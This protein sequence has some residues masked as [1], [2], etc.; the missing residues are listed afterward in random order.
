[1]Y[2][3]SKL[4]G[5][6]LAL[7]LG[8]LGAHLFYYKKYI[9]GLLYLIFCWTYIPVFLGWVDMIFIK[10]W[11]NQLN[12]INNGESTKNTPSPIKVLLD[13]YPNDIPITK[14]QSNIFGK[15]F[16]NEEEI[17]I[18]KY[19]RLKTPPSI[20]QSVEEVINPKK[21]NRNT[22]GIRVEF[23]YSRSHSDF[24]KKSANYKNRTQGKTREIP[25]QAYWTTFDHMNEQQLKWYFHWREETLKGNYLEVDLSYIFVFVYELLNYSFNTNAAFNVSM[26]VRLY[27]NYKEMHPKLSN[28]LPR[29]IQDMLNELGEEELASEWTS[30]NYVPPIYKAIIEEE[31]PLN[32]ISITHWK[33][34]IRN[35]RETKFFTDNKNKIYKVFK[36]GLLLLEEHYNIDNEKIINVWFKS[37]RVRSVNHLFSG[38]VIG[39][40]NEAKHVYHLEIQPTDTLYNEITTLFRLSENVTRTLSGEK[41]EIK[42]DEEVLPFDFK[43]KLV[44]RFTNGAKK[45]NERFKMVKDKDNQVMGT[46]IPNPPNE[47]VKVVTL[48]KPVIEF[49][50]DNIKRLSKENLELQIV[51]QHVEINEDDQT[52]DKET[53]KGIVNPFEIE[54]VTR[55][56]EQSTAEVETPF[57]SYFDN[58]DGDEKEFINSLSEAEKEFLSLFSN[59]QYSQVEATTFAKRNGKMLGLFLSEINEKA[60]EHLGDNIVESEEDSII[61]YEEFTDIALM[62][63]GA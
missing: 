10:R 4:V 53:S 25:L 17:I 2:Q 19:S 35:Y 44:D 49:N 3:K 62:L 5:Y 43:N 16:Y 37:K 8:G 36:E 41:R 14:N 39:R 38:A 54:E 21:A 63:K 24:I 60:N 42:V 57:D 1:M 6:L 13:Q 45:T 12:S 48:A 46:A 56:T 51:F 26:L 31:R 47:E 33:P 40:E 11:H 28:Y 23:S 7:F 18:T 34:Y 29:W 32:N 52:D 50:D 59:G 61:L 15:P 55:A 9:R 20:L 27:E 58:S 30:R 22:D